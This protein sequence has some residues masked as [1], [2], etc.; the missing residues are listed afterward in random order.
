MFSL[1]GQIALVTG[2]SQGIGRA[3]ALVLAE[4]GADVAVMARSIDKCEAVAEEI[5]S[6]F[7]G[8]RSLAVRGDLGVA[9]EIKAAVD[10]VATELG[11]ISILVNNAAITRDGLMLRM[12]RD[13][14]DQVINTNLTGVFLMTQ[15]VLPMMTKARKGRIINLT[16]VVAQSG[17]AGQ[18]NYISAKSGI[19]GMTKAV[20]REYAARNI[21]VNAVSPG[22]IETPMTAVLPEA[23][24]NAMLEQI[25]LK[26]PGTDMDVAHAVA[27]LA[28]DKAGY[29]TGQVV[30]VNGG[31]YM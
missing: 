22:F 31:M 10:K 13:D 2:G 7:A 24:R 6:R 17:N 28:S 14:W 11:P 19:I 1:A 16:S 4:L 8:R 20:A 27:F 15:A 23:A 3:T 26:R 21:T 9:D 12:K 29:I 25:P 18:V 30:N 5:K